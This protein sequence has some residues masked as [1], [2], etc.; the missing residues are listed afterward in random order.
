MVKCGERDE[1]A[2]SAFVPL[3]KAITES[4]CDPLSTSQEKMMVSW[5]PERSTVPARSMLPSLFEPIAME[6]TALPP[7]HQLLVGSMKLP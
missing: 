6:E 4:V 1:S 2:L 5:L 7:I 3:P